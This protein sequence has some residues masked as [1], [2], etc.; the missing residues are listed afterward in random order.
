MFDSLVKEKQACNLLL[1]SVL[2]TFTVVMISYLIIIVKCVP[3]DGQVYRK[4]M[5]L[6]HV[7]LVVNGRLHK[8]FVLVHLYIDDCY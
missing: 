1:L 6:V 3:F 2:F 5:N 4:Y 8:T 7:S